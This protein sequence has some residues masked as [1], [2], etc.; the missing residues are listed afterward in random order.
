MVQTV[1]A[2]QARGPECGPGNPRRLEAVTY[3]YNPRISVARW[4]GETE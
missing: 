3:I 2:T 1:L 4:E